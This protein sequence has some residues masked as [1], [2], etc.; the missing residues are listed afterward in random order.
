ML[1][2][3]LHDPDG[4]EGPPGSVAGLGLLDLETAMRPDKRLTEAAGRHRPTGAPV[5]GYEMHIGVTAGAATPR[6]F[7]D[8][9]TDDRRVGQG[10]VRKCKSGWSPIHKKKTKKNT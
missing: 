4:I 8:L 1:G 2:R 6:A 3:R 10:C 5:H 7:L 9:R